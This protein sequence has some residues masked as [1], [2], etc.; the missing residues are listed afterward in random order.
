[1]RKYFFIILFLAFFIVLPVQAQ[2]APDINA[3]FIPG[4]IWFSKFPFFVNEN[5]RIYSAL[6]NNSEYDIEGKLEFKSGE[7]VIAQKN[8]SLAQ[9][10]GARDIWVDWTAPQGKHF[11]NIR[12]SEA[13]ISNADGVLQDYSF[14]SEIIAQKEVFVDADNDDDGIG[15]IDDDDDDNDNISDIEEIKLGTNPFKADASSSSVQSVQNDPIDTKTDKTKEIIA[16]TT[17]KIGEKIPKNILGF[18]LEK[19]DDFAEKQINA[20]EQK[21]QELSQEKIFDLATKQNKSQEEETASSSPLQKKNISKEEDVAK[22][23]LVSGFSVFKRNSALFFINALIFLL[24]YK[25]FLFLFLLLFIYKL[26]KLIL[27]IFIRY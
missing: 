24:K 15:N 22:D 16:E 14:N 17:K 26:L 8:F 9:G 13:V 18:D 23:N 19:F 11:L 27:R 4:P 10:S 6:Y 5:I 25:I 7:D 12:I 3:G 1:M 20:L 2:E 21:K